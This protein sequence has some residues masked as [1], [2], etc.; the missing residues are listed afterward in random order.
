MS[1]NGAAQVDLEAYLARIGYD[2]PRAATL[3][4]LTA[5]QALH[6]AAI[7]FEAIDVLLDRGVDLTPAAIDAKLIGA[8]RGGYC[9]EQNNLFR[10]ALLALGFEVESLI[11]RVLWMAGP[12]TPP[13]PR[14]HMALCVSIDGTSWLA[15]VGFGSC[16]LTAPLLFDSAGPQV[17]THDTFRL[18][19]VERELR[20]ELRLGDA[21]QAVYQ[22]SREPQA[23]IDYEPANWFTSTHPTSYFRRD[24]V[25]ART[26]PQA[27]YTLANNRLSVRRPDGSTERRSLTADELERVLAD[28]FALPVEAAWRPVLERAVAHGVG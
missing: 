15:D 25:V 13:R 2:G 1:S 27:R 6:P 8:G 28:V 9:F 10:R 21:W 20:L 14:S 17:T 4:T 18:R 22:L 26:T 12:D 7:T 16:V 23:M 3:D 19:S 5:L 11:A 24:L